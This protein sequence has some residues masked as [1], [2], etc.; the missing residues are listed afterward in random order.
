MEPNSVLAWAG[1]VANRMGKV[2]INIDPLE[3]LIKCYLNEKEELKKNLADSKRLHSKQYYELNKALARIK[4][5][6]GP[7]TDKDTEVSNKI[8]EE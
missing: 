2:E 7:E 5:L 6:E 4:E 1:I 3:M 8:G